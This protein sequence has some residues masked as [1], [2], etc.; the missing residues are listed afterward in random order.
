MTF[1]PALTVP[2]SALRY[3]MPLPRPTTLAARWAAFAHAG[4]SVERTLRFLKVAVEA[5]DGRAVKVAVTTLEGL[6]LAPFLHVFGLVA[7]SVGWQALPPFHQTLAQCHVPVPEASLMGVAARMVAFSQVPAFAVVGGTGGS[8]AVTR[9][10]NDLMEIV[11]DAPPL[12][13]LVAQAFAVLGRPVPADHLVKCY[14]LVEQFGAPPKV[15][16]RPAEA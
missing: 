15:A 6:G 10:V 12:A 9:A 13:L 16:Y 14:T 7:T 4:G 8:A 5:G 2:R 1:R 11:G 3:A